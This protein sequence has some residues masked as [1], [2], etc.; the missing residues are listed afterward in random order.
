MRW[1]QKPS[2]DMRKVRIKVTKKGHLTIG[3]SRTLRRREDS[4]ASR[5]LRDCFEVPRSGWNLDPSPARAPGHRGAAATRPPRAPRRPHPASPLPFTAQLCPHA[6]R[7]GSGESWISTVTITT[8]A[9]QSGAHGSRPS[10]GKL[11]L[12]LAGRFGFGQLVT[13]VRVSSA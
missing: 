12:G 6:S 3:I 11:H 1:D 10:P 5:R 7:L 13:K 2:W 4:V 9:S 8:P